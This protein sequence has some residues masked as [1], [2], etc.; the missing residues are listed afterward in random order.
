MK[1]FLATV[2]GA[3]EMESKN[4]RHCEPRSGVA[5]QKLYKNWMAVSRYALLAMTKN[6]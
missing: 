3:V 2:S 5:I 6:L 4:K 1:V